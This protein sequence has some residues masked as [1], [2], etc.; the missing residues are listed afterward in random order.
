MPSAVDSSSDEARTVAAFTDY[1]AAT[2]RTRS[3]AAARLTLALMLVVGP[4]EY[5]LLS[6]RPE[7]AAWQ[8]TWMLTS[9][10]PFAI[11][12][13][14]VW[15]S[16]RVARHVDVAVAIM[17]A[18]GFGTAAA[19]VAQIGG[20]ETLYAGIASIVPMLSVFLLVP[21]RRRMWIAA[22]T[23]LSFLGVFFAVRP[24]ALGYPY[25]AVPV[26]HATLSV[27]VS[28]LVGELNYTLAR[29]H[30]LQAHELAG[31]AARLDRAVRRRTSEVVELARNLVSLEETE[32][33]RIARE[34]HDELG[35]QLTAVRLDAGS[36]AQAVREALG[37]D[38]PAATRAVGI[39]AQIAL[40]QQTVRDVV[41][42]LRPP[43]LDDFDLAT[44]LEL[45]VDRF[46]QPGHVRVDYENVLDGMPL[47]DTQAT[48]VFRVLQEALTNAVRHA[49]AEG[50][51][52]RLGRDGDQVRLVVEDDGRGV[53]AARLRSGFGLRG[54]RERLRLVGGAISVEPGA[55]G[56]TTVVATFPLRVDVET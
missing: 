29:G 36:A 32:R 24:D 27:V 21:L 49:D 45:L 35:Q 31:E 1:C 33:T 17:A 10:V 19:G 41:F 50:V 52:V 5:L 8:R 2:N 39:E 53:D 47:T 46:R 9:A 15:A 40:A 38:T 44:A 16:A 11:G 55:A 34:L 48:T 28:I 13:F 25:A 12:G 37:E 3:W 18:L 30:F 7:V 54:M 43:A 20:L 51:R 14:L 22:I 56:G 42:S 23:P 4:V 26:F 6:D